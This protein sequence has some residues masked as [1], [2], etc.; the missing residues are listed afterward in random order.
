MKDSFYFLLV[1]C[2]MCVKSFVT[3]LLPLGVSNKDIQ[4]WVRYFNFQI[5]MAKGL[6][7]LGW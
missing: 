3:Q 6:I 2:I 1:S 7:N 5:K 4:N